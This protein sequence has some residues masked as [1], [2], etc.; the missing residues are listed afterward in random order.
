MVR[1]SPH[2]THVHRRSPVALSRLPW[3]TRAPATPAT[4]Y[5]VVEFV[6]RCS[7]ATSARP[8]GAVARRSRRLVGALVDRVVGHASLVGDVSDDVPSQAHHHAR[9]R[10]DGRGGR[11]AHAHVRVRRVDA[12]VPRAERA[13]SRRHADG[14]TLRSCSTLRRRRHG[15]RGRLRRGP[16][17]LLVDAQRVHMA[18]RCYTRD[19]M[20]QASDARSNGHNQKRRHCDF[21]TKKN[22]LLVCSSL[23]AQTSARM[24]EE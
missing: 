24:Y 7:I 8:P 11:H 4:G 12:R 19:I 9:A 15:D 1:R 18:N 21:E 6:V 3:V 20:I 5:I 22:M 17:A 2:N 13:S 14:E 23:C 10:D 16:R